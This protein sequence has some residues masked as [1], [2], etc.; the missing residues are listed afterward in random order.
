[1][2]SKISRIEVKRL[3]WDFFFS[4]FVTVFGILVLATF[5]TLILH[6]FGNALP[7]VQSPALNFKYSVA[8]DDFKR[9]LSS[10]QN[11]S[12]YLGMTQLQNIWYSV[13]YS[14]C[15]LRVDSLAKQAIGKNTTGTVINQTNKTFA[16]DCSKRPIALLG[17]QRNILAFVGQQGRLEIFELALNIDGVKN[18]IELALQG[19]FLLPQEMHF[20]EPEIFSEN[21]SEQNL[22]QW[23]SQWRS[24]F[25]NGALALARDTSQYKSNN[26]Q[27]TEAQ[28]DGQSDNIHVIEHALGSLAPITVHALPK[29][30]MLE[31]VL[32]RKVWL[33]VAGTN[34]QELRL[35]D[36]YFELAQNISFAHEI[37][38]LVVSTNQLDVMV[39]TK[40]QTLHKFLLLNQNGQFLL[41]EAYTVTLPEI[42][43]NEQGI[44]QARAAVL[45]VFDNVHNML[46]LIQSNGLASLLNSVTG[47]IFE[48]TSLSL[49]FDAAY[50]R[51]ELF[52]KHDKRFS[53]YQ[54]DNLQ[55]FTSLD[56]LF[57]KN[58]YSGYPD[59]AY[60][61][62]TSV[63]SSEQSP[64]FSVVPLLM[65]SLKA[66]LLALIVAVPLALGGA[67]YT[68]Y[69]AS[70]K[71]RNRIKPSIEMLEAIPSVI[72]GFIAAVWLAPFAEQHLLSIFFIIM[73]LP[74]VIVVFSVLHSVVHAKVA[75][76]QWANKPFLIN[77]LLIIAAVATVVLL[78]LLFSDGANVFNDT[79]VVSSITNLTLSKTAVV[80]SLALGIAISP[81]IY[82]LIDDALSEVPD[83]VKQ[84]S[85]ALGATPI[86]T[87]TK[88]VLVV[89]FPSIISAVMLGFGRAFGETMIVL[90][91]TGNTPIANWD[92][93]SGLRTLTSNLAIELQ[94]AQLESTLYYILFLTAAILFVFTFVINTIAA[95]LKRNMRKGSEV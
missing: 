83:G 29:S 79:T 41:R 64:K 15:S 49:S 63:A 13:T 90:M 76:T 32:K 67:I 73:L 26:L 54:V 85:F 93:F 62:Q 55:G 14:N 59:P 89:A 6:V 16:P 31:A 28:A 56:V 36:K 71:V 1:M 40:D 84:A 53:L 45:M 46:L 17:P 50:I 20:N 92:L 18:D 43:Q 70:P 37:E 8:S 51:S 30:P 5:V 11:D 2:K 35:L 19:S 47:E 95:L 25:D 80:V 33:Q 66:S 86:Q 75:H 9:S 58:H 57:G 3:R 38:A 88:V 72:I 60:V 42:E 74:F 24:R 27:S 82:T 7:L 61:W 65:G 10:D 87:L 69:F 23:Q 44:Q 91:V 77:A 4:R 78:G 22:K 12:V 39:L 68:A 81:T 52:L 34:K 94:E 48:D 21:L